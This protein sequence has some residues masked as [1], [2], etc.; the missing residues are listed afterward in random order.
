MDNFDTS[1]LQKGLGYVCYADSKI[2]I[3]GG[4]KNIENEDVLANSQY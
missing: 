1:L 2:G 3:Q 4:K